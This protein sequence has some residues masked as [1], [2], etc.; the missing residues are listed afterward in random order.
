MKIYYH[1]LVETDPLKGAHLDLEDYLQGILNLAS[2]LVRYAVNAF[3]AGD[4]KKPFQVS[5]IFIFLLS[6]K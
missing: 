4:N 5:F 3:V 2:E 1:V 6:L